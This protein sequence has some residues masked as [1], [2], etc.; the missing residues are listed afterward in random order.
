MSQAYH[1]LKNTVALALSRVI[2]RAGT[3]VLAFFVSRTLGAVG[4]GI[5]S[6][7]MVYY[8]LVAT[9][10]EMGAAN[11]LA[12]EIAKDRTKASRYVIHVGFLAI[13][14]S[15]LATAL[16]FVLVPHLGYSRELAASVYV[17]LLA[18]IPGIVRRIQETIFVAY[19]RVEFITYTTLAT[20]FVNLGLC[21][22]LLKKG[23]G[24]VSLVAAFVLIQFLINIFYFVFATRYVTN[25]DW[26]FDLRF[27]LNLIREIRSFAGS[28]LLSGF[29]SRPEIL[30][31]SLM[32]NEAV[33]G[34]YSAALRL[35]D[36][37]QLIP[38]S[39]MTNV[40]PVL[41]KSYHVAD[42]KP[43]L[44]LD[45]SI[46]YLLAASLPL[47]AGIFVA[48][49]PIVH[50]VY[51]PDF[52]P[53]V[54]VLRLLV[55]GIP[56]ACLLAILWRALV[57]R[58][59]QDLVL[60]ADMVSTVGRL[61]AGYWL[62]SSFASRGAAMATLLSLLSHNLLLT[63]YLRRDGTRLNLFRL[64]WRSALAAFGMG[65]LIWPLSQHLQI[66]A[67]IPIAGVIYIAL[68]I[69]L[70]V[71]SADDRVAVF[72]KLW[73]SGVTLYRDSSY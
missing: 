7:A 9:A 49:R 3:F 24:V 17:V 39:Y 4:L 59:Q 35:V 40:F 31:L 58:G 27:A 54:A 15:V 56:L 2:E 18:S 57:A 55:W 61:A 12:R 26:T 47:A 68:S 6:T 21:L 33:V 73:R 70:R 20:T 52:G 51:G 29:F 37:W 72:R 42:Q 71:F 8:S 48:A 67:L 63:F 1:I 32:R 64:G 46:H 50:L 23:H 13:V 14:I 30:I 16:S 38:E 53:S 28:S 22:H 66:W 62:I 60:R 10:A 45:K 65:A 19:Q 69:Y 11:L 34:F 44:I 41:S 43:Q 36:A 5:Y 25:L